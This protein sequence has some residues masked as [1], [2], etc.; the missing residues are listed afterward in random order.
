M[1]LHADRGAAGGLSRVR[2]RD[3][4][5]ECAGCMA[6][7][8]SYCGTSSDGAA[9]PGR[10]TCGCWRKGRSP[11]GGGAAGAT[12]G[13]R[14]PGLRASAALVTDRLLI[15][16]GGAGWRWP[17][18]LFVSAAFNPL[19]RRDRHVAIAAIARM[20]NDEWDRS[21]DGDRRRLG[22]GG[23]MRLTPDRPARRNQL[24]RGTAR[25][26]EEFPSGTFPGA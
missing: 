8:R 20:T 2:S 10:S 3:T 18:C 7:K 15:G 21:R 9:T 14:T 1:S 17:G 26:T 25:G 19:D 16:G 22:K 23:A 11:D 12:G 4:M 13:L 24:G 5:M 6:P